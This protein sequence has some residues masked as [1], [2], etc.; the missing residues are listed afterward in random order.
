MAFLS[1][2]SL[3]IQFLC[4]VHAIAICDIAHVRDVLYATRADSLF[5]REAI[6]P[7]HTGAIKRLIAWK[8]SHPLR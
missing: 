4:R 1:R 7:V 2:F 3:A 8:I 5:L 6:K